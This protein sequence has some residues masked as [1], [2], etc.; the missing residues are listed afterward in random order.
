MDIGYVTTALP[1]LQNE[2]DVNIQLDEDL[3]SWFVATFWI[4]GI[5]TCTLGGWLGGY[6]GR[7]KTMILAAPVVLSGFAI[8]GSAKSIAF[9]F[10]GRILV[11]TA[12]SCSTTSSGT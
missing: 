7:R 11:S 2:T 9:L 12:L 3:G 4:S 8:L 1:Q 10:L 6:L 5:V